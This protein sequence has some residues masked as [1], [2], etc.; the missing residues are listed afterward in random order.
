MAGVGLWVVVL[1]WRLVDLQVVRR[2]EFAKK[3]RK[4][5]ERTVELP[6]RRGQITDAAGRSLAV[7]AQ[8][9]SVFAIPS[10]VEDPAAVAAALA[11]LVA[12]QP[13]S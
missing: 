8:V 1:L 12:R 13:A 6:P 11:P 3:A 5:H 9:D 7:T 2:E 10:E 4:Q